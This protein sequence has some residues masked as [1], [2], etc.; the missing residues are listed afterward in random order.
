MDD[1]ETN[2]LGCAVAILRDHRAID[3]ETQEELMRI[4]DRV[5]RIARML[6][7]EQ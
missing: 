3:S 2:I 6:E 1:R 7:R 5:E 4:A